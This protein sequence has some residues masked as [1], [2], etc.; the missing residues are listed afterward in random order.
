MANDAISPAPPNAGD[1]KAD[2]LQLP[3][4][5]AA[6][7]ATLPPSIAASLA[8]IAGVAAN[9]KAPADVKSDDSGQD[10]NAN[11]GPP[12]RKLDAGE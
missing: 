12:P 3:Q 7:F 9:D 5:G 4:E 11:T 1:P 2:V 6:D 10:D 8:R